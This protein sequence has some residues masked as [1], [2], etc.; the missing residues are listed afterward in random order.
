R[1]SDRVRYSRVSHNRAVQRRG[2]KASGA[3]SVRSGSSGAGHHFSGSD[4]KHQQ[5]QIDKRFA[6]AERSWSGAVDTVGF[7]LGA[8]SEGNTAAVRLE[9]ILNR[10]A[11]RGPRQRS[12]RA[13]NGWTESHPR[14]DGHIFAEPQ[15]GKL[16]SRTGGA[17]RVPSVESLLG[18]RLSKR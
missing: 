6:G 15:L 10:P 13:N 17:G 11:A 1:L 16:G 9:S 12:Y 2:L 8:A 7:A 3:G 4:R 14:P 18:G 5:R